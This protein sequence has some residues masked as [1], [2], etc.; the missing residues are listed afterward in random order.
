MYSPPEPAIIPAISALLKAPNKLITPPKTQAHNTNEGDNNS[1]DMGA[2]F[3][4][5]PD[6]MTELTTKI[7]AAAKERLRTN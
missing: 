5:T 6:P 3:L 7:V 4:Y 1:A 2:T